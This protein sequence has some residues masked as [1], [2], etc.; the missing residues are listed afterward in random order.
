MSYIT[1]LGTASRQL[2]AVWHDCPSPDTAPSR[3]CNQLGQLRAAGRSSCQLTSGASWWLLQSAEGLVP[4]CTLPAMPLRAHDFS[5][6]AANPLHWNGKRCRGL[7]AS[8]SLHWK[9]PL[10]SALSAQYTGHLWSCIRQPTD[11]MLGTVSL[12]SWLALT[13]W[14]QK[15]PHFLRYSQEG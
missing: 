1:A 10:I 12:H 3:G 4:R 9:N 11:Q 14:K 15:I 7:G 6:S 2:T 8:S 5:S 13:E